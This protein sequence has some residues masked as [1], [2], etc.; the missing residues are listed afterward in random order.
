MIVRQLSASGLS[1]KAK[2]LYKLLEHC[3]LCPRRCGVNR[4][5]NEKGFCGVGLSPL[6]SSVGP[7]FGEEPELVGRNGSGT[8]FF[9][10]CNLGCLFCQNYDISHLKRGDEISAKNLAKEMLTLQRIGCHNINLVTPTHVIPQIIEAVIY[11]V[12]KGLDLPIVYNTG[13]Y[14]SLDAIKILDGIIDI[15]MP[16]AKYSDPKA[17]K[18]Y[19]QAE[20]YPKV[21]KDAIKEMHRQ[22][23]DLV[24]DKGIA[25][26]GLLVRHLV[27]PNGVAGTKE[28]MH[29]IAEEISKNTYVNIMDQ[30]RPCYKAVEFPEIN[31]RITGKEYEEA[32]D[33]AKSFGLWRGFLATDYTD[34]LN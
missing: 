5:N 27:M 34:F 20:D 28:I 26:K 23:G 7:H 10:G 32:L 2:K 4:L 8:I 31:R 17:S 1:Q 3:I 22:V 15:Y 33:I 11:A 29:F 25:V 14:D 12:E 30:Y 24:V 21:M 6:V 16:D 18:K 13:G 19:S 9:A